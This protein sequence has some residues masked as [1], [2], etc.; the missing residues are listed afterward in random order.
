MA[1]AAR[2]C[3]GDEGKPD[4]DLLRHRQR[5]RS[6]RQSPQLEGFRARGVEVLLLPDQVD[7]FWVR[8]AIWTASRSSRSRKA[9]DLSL[10]P[11]PKAQTSPSPK[12]AMRSAASSLSSRKRWVTR[13]PT[14][15]PPTA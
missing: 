13:C 12:P 5:S 3:R 7:S 8:G 15:A 6:H 9:A 11:C 1:F 4:G 10:I 2:L 14:C